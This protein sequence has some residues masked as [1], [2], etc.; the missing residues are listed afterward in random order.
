[1]EGAAGIYGWATDKLNKADNL[2]NHLF[3][4]YDG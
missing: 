1:V 3:E 4:V 2:K